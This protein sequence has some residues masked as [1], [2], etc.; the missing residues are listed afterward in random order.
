[1]FKK[2][3]KLKQQM[4]QTLMQLGFGSNKLFKRMGLDMMISH[5]G[6]NLTSMERRLINVARQIY[7]C[8]R[9]LVVQSILSGLEEEC[10]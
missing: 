4:M 3:Q 5:E 8:R 7:D 2:G 9:V 1:M 6:R 10:R